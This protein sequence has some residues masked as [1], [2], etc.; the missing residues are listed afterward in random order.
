MS[1]GETSDRTVTSLPPLRKGGEIVDAPADATPIDAH[2]TSVQ[3]RGK[4]LLI[5]LDHRRVI[6]P[7]LGM[8]GSWHVY[9]QRSSWRKPARRAGHVRKIRTPQQTTVAVCSTPKILEILTAARFRRYVWP[10]QIGPDL[11]EPS[12]SLEEALRRLRQ[13]GPLA[14]DEA[15]MN[16]AIVSGIGNVY[17]AEI[18]FLHQIHPWTPVERLDDQWLDT[19]LQRAR[20][21]LL[22]NCHGY[23]RRTRRSLDTNRHWSMARSAQTCFRC[24]RRIQMQRQGEQGRSTYS[25]KTCQVPTD[26]RVAPPA[27][28]PNVRPE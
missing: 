6:H 12:F 17:K 2:V 10:R 11:L 19:L 4:H 18:L 21:A 24:G 25:C 8:T 23:P 22:Q 26:R 13:C 27:I 16:Q 7:P 1:E 20:Q 3:L 28:P 15:V 9:R 14:I 5:H